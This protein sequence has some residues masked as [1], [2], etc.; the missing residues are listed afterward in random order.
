[1]VD[2]DTRKRYSEDLRHFAAEVIGV[3]EYETR[4]DDLVFDSKDPAIFAV[5]K[6]VWVLYD[7]FRTD[8][9]RG[10]WALTAETREKIARGI[11]FLQ[12]DAEY[13]WPKEQCDIPA[14][15]A[16]EAEIILDFMTFGM[17]RKQWETLFNPFLAHRWEQRQEWMRPFGDVDCWPFMDREELE[18]A[19]TSPM[20]LNG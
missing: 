13:R 10:E 12:T 20:L 17:L 18:K 7:D 14:N 4:T 6:S 8:R 2:L 11:L 3:D 1:M 5:W 16:A 15:V 9:L 19:K